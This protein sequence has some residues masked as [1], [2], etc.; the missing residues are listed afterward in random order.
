[1]TF[2]ANYQGIGDMLCAPYMQDAMRRR[3]EAGLAYAVS[4]APVNTGGPHPGRYKAS[5]QVHSGVRRGATSRAYG[6]LSNTSP[7][8]PYVEYGNGTP[9]FQGHHILARALDVMKS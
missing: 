4:I 7:E 6:E 8:A 2:Q 5:F 3:A 9:A 1:M